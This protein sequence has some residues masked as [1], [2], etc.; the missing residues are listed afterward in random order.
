[1]TVLRS[2]VDTNVFVYAA[3]ESPEERDKHK[4]A[5]SLLVADPDELVISTQVLQEFYVTV[6][7]KLRTPLSTQ[8]AASA[9]RAM[10]KLDVVHV[11]VPLVF[12]AMD[13][14]RA[15]RI[16]LWDALM[17]EAAR[18][19]GCSRILSEDLSNG[20]VIRNVVVENPFLP[21]PSGP[22]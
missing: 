22:G 21:D 20:Q 2:F 16:S 17:I 8:R 7:R 11:D 10:A 15:A 1:M 14:S 6:T 3:D 12:A 9:V 5:S 19:A 4:I 13:T 18:Q